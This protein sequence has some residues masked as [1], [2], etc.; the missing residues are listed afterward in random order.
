[1]KVVEELEKA[2][3]NKKEKIHLQYITKKEECFFGFLAFVKFVS[4]IWLVIRPELLN[5]ML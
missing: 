4:S 3:K 1:M 5:E 2:E